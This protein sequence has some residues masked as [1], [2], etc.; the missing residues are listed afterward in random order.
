MFSPVYPAVLSVNSG[1]IQLE[2][3][4]LNIKIVEA[5]LE[6]LSLLS[7]VEQSQKRLLIL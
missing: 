6:C 2:V 4:Y 5:L 1:V 7:V 3:L